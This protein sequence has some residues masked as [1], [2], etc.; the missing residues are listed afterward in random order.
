MLKYE[1]SHNHLALE[2][3]ISLE[4]QRLNQQLG[5]HVWE[6][7]GNRD[8]IRNKEKFLKKFIIFRKVK[9]VVLKGKSA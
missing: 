9:T 6:L 2:D 4:R 8:N 1:E 3:S 5:V 7:T